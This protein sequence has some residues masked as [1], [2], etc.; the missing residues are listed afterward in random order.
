MR[1]NHNTAKKIKGEIRPTRI[2]PD[3]DVINIRKGESG[4]R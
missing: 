1:T 2:L 3:V 4:R